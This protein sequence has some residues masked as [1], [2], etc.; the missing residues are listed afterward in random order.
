MNDKGFKTFVSTNQPDVENGILNLQKLNKMHKKLK[1][2][3]N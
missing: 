1:R 3:L 2:D